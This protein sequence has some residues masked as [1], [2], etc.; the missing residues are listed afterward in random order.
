MTNAVTLKNLIE[1]A[2]EQAKTV[3]IGLGQD[4]MPSWV[5]IDNRGK[6]SILGTPWQDDSEKQLARIALQKKIKRE[7]IVAYSFVSEAWTATKPAGW[8]LPPDYQGV[9]TEPDRREIVLAF[10]TDGKEQEL[11]VWSIHRDEKGNV[12]ALEQ[13]KEDNDVP[14]QGWMTE[15]LK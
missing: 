14:M 11:G 10:A 5:F 2:G 15:L 12:F 3:M 13:S 8:T 1:L 9:R 4:L 6:V 7:H